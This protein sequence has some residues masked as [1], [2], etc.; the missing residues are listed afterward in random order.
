MW[1][2]VVVVSMHASAC[3]RI[4]LEKAKLRKREARE[5]EFASRERGMLRVRPVLVSVGWALLR[6]AGVCVVASDTPGLSLERKARDIPAPF[7]PLLPLALLL[8]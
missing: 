6:G 8:A 3:S 7:S 2:V 5:R 4:I 1:S